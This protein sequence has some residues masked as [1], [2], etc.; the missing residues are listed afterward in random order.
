MTKV[1]EVHPPGTTNVCEKCHG[2][3]VNFVKENYEKIVFP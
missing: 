1:I 2:N 3:G